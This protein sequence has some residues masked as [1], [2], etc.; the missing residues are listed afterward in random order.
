MTADLPEDV[1]RYL[2]IRDRQHAD[3]VHFTLA[4]MTGRERRLVRE[5]AVMGHVLGERYGAAHGSRD[6][7]LGDPE[8]VARVVDGCLGQPDLYPV[9]ASLRGD[10]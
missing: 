6:G 9:M 5:A 7:G 3:A 8:I 4:T 1:L 2:A 10:A